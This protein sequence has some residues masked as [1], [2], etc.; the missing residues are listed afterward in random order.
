[1]LERLV[2]AT[3]SCGWTVS[4]ENGIT[5]TSAELVNAIRCTRDGVKKLSGGVLAWVSVW[6]EVQTCIWPS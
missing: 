6:S 2:S 1:M 4:V 5:S 3:L